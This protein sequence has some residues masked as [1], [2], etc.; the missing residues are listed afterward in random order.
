LI[1][2]FG[3]NILRHGPIDEIK[4]KEASS[5]SNGEAPAKECPKCNS[6]IHAAY[7][8]CPDCGHE[9]PPPET[10][11]I[12]TKA[13]TSSILSGEIEDNTYKVK[14]IY[15]SVHTKKGAD[16]D[17]PKTLRIEYEVG[18]YNFVS[19]W[20]CPEHVGWARGKFEDWWKERSLTLP[21]PT[22]AEAVE[23]ACGGAL[24]RSEEITVRSISGQKF[25]RIIA[26]TLGEIPAC[27][28]PGWE[29]EGGLEPAGAFDNND[30]WIDDIPF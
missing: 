14:Q 8:N 23:L 2:D 9:F 25:D 21:P 3:G 16:E 30:D 5:S 19:E 18:M 4:I 24:A 28:E 22:A 7:R 6:L 20:V 17:T 1:L 12:E 27:R 13:D 29:D 11:N 26:H 10:G 15:Y